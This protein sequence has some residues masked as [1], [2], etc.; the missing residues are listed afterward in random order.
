MVSTRYRTKDLRLARCHIVKAAQRIAQQEMVIGRLRLK[1]SPSG[2]A[3]ELLGR[4]YD[5]QRRK[6]DRLKLIEAMV[7]VKA[8][9]CMSAPRPRGTL[10][11]PL[12]VVR[13]GANSLP[14]RQ[15]RTPCS[16]DVWHPYLV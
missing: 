6:L 4:L 13:S 7:E 10:A 12:A 2:L 15:S 8:Q 5:D 16:A 3:Y 1:G 11:P 14:D 9:S